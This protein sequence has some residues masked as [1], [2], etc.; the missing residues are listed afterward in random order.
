MR[1]N[2][3]AFVLCIGNATNNLQVSLRTEKMSPNNPPHMYI[4]IY[5]YM[6]VFV[7]I[8]ICSDTLPIRIQS[9]IRISFPKRT[10][11]KGPS[12]LS[13]PLTNFPKRTSKKGPSNLS[14]PLMN[15]GSGKLEEA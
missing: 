11:K 5:I 8:C 4:H 2:S 13:K 12:T 10:S 3:C 6:C 1:M 15:V 9:R 14:K 7:C